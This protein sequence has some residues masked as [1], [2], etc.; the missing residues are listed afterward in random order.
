MSDVAYGTMRKALRPCTLNFVKETSCFDMAN[1]QA[2]KPC[3]LLVRI[4]R[5]RGAYYLYLLVRVRRL[6]VAYYLR[7]LGAF[8][9][10]WLLASARVLEPFVLDC[11]R[12][13]LGVGSVLW[14]F[15]AYYLYLLRRLR[16]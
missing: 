14:L 16:L 13:L 4:R 3:Y 9:S 11:S 12:R 1:A 10:V 2:E 8:V 6:Y 15:G 5:L 7:L